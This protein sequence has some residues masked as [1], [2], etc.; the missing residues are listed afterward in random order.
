MAPANPRRC[1]SPMDFTRPMKAKSWLMARPAT[2]A[3]PH[4]A[5]ALGI[6]MV[7]QHFM[8][9]DTMT[10]AENIVL[11]AEPGSAVALD[12]ADRQRRNPQALR[13]IQTGRQSKRSY[14]TS[15]SG[16]ATAR[17][18]AESALPSRAPADPRRADRRFD[19]AGSR[20]VLF[21]P[22][23]HA[24]AGKD[25]CDHHAQAGRGAGNLR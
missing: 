21:H 7:H 11:G 18:T 19:A 5:I 4:D 8:L 15:F 1:V 12:L 25:S 13:R 3:T 20:R 6:G 16:P 24:R 14:R 2:S 22:A 9:V 23:P 17:R 10:V